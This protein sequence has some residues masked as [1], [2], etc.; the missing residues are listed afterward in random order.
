MTI[1]TFDINC[2][3]AFAQKM[4]QEKKTAVGFPCNQNVKLA[5]F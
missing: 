4:V 2:L 5:D 1:P 3:N